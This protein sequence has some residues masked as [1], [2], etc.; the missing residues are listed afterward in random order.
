MP[1]G[2]INV[3]QP[4]SNLERNPGWA[5]VAI[6]FPVC[7]FGLLRIRDDLGNCVGLRVLTVGFKLVK[8][9]SPKP[10]TATPPALYEHL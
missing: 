2:K 3:N 1:K 8:E 7:R 9:W 4:S 5:S 10:S 6:L